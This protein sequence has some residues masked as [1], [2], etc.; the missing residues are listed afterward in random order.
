MDVKAPSV[1]LVQ[2]TYRYAEPR[3]PLGVSYLMAVLK[4]SGI[5]TEII[6]M[7][8]DGIRW[9]DSGGN[10]FT[11]VGI[12]VWTTAFDEASRIAKEAR[13]RG[14]YVMAGGPH[15]H[16]DP[17]SLLAAG[18]NVV[19]DGDGEDVIVSMV[20]D[21]P[22]GI[23]TGLTPFR[24]PIIP[25]LSWTHAYPYKRGIGPV[26]ATRGCPG[27]CVYC[28]RVNGNVSRLRDI[29]NLID[30]LTRY[31][32]GHFVEFVDD[33]MTYDKTWFMALCNRA[34]QR[35]VKLTGSAI[36]NGTRANTLD[37]EMFSALKSALNL[38]NIMLGLESTDAKTRRLSGRDITPDEV[39]KAIN[40]CKAHDVVPGLFMM[41]GLPGSTTTSDMASIEWVQKR[42]PLFSNWSMTYAFP[43]TPL[44]RWVD[45]HGRWLIPRRE[46][47]VRDMAG[48]TQWD[49]VEYPASER[50]AVFEYAHRTVQDTGKCP[51]H[52]TPLGLIAAVGG[53]SGG[54]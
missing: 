21:R 9:K 32:Q 26:Q 46:Y 14:L 17:Q 27:K 29:D 33:C 8:F 48:L 45:K 4:Q 28:G 2:P 35:G 39:D 1:L 10:P 51:K 37:D 49:T 44:E 38:S 25:D 50:L 43:N 24:T 15:A 52:R 47:T 22:N 36:A 34:M 53:R 20:R 5:H 11:H 54:H 3:I 12:T 30:E 16:A 41:I 19:C 18:F 23:I 40:I 13:E 7:A 42:Q 6:D 31:W